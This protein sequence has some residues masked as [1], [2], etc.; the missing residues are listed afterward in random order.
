[1]SSKYLDQSVVNRSCNIRA[2]DITVDGSLNAPSISVDTSL[3]A[4]SIIVTNAVVNDNLR[5]DGATLRKVTNHVA[6]Q[7]GAPTNSVTLNQPYGYIITDTMTS[8]AG[9]GHT[10][11]TLLNSYVNTSSMMLYSIVA[12]NQPLDGTAGTPVLTGAY[13]NSGEWEFSVV[14]TNA[15]NALN[16]KV[17][18]YFDLISLVDP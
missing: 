4:T 13:K 17:N 12:Y 7:V 8:A 16:G 15:T 14:N 3:T 1:M 18:I 11:F 10:E 9:G 6:T 5:I 2:Y